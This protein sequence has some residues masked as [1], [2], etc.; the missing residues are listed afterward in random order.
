[1]GDREDVAAKVEGAGSVVDRMLEGTHTPSIPG[2]CRTC[3]H[4]HIYRRRLVTR[5]VCRILGSDVPADI[6]ECSGYE[7]RGKMPFYEM[8]GIAELVQGKGRPGFIGASGGAPSRPVAP[9]GD[10]T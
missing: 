2:V 9:K 1:M 5:V 7:Q 3:N 4:A 10:A 8:V 6:E